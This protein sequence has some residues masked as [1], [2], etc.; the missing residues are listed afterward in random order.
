MELSPAFMYIHISYCVHVYGENIHI[1]YCVHV[2]GENIHIP[3]CVHLYGEKNKNY[4]NTVSVYHQATLYH[5][6]EYTTLIKQI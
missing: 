3:Y 2:Y 6:P 4:E 1:S 5:G